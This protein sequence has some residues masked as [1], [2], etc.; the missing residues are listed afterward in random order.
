MVHHSTS[1]L[2]LVA[3]VYITTSDKSVS[4][5]HV[6]SAL[7]LAHPDEQYCASYLLY[8]TMYVHAL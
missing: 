1:G 7:H 6:P 5:V 3:L 4:A 2:H 8:C